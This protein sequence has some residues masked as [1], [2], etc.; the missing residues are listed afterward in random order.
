[1]TQETVLDRPA[2]GFAAMERDGALAPFDFMRR[3]LRPEDVAFDVLFCGICH[4]DLHMIGK[5]GQEYPLVPGHEMVGRVTEVGAAASGFAQGDLVAVSVIVDSCRECRP[6]Q[7]HDETYCEAGATS[8][9]D[10][11]DRIDG[12]RTRGGFA[13]TFVA[14]QRFVYHLPEGLDP[15]GAAPLLCAGLTSFAPMRHWKIGPGQTVGVVG[16]G[17]LGHLGVKFARAMGA[18]VVAFTSTP[19]KEPDALALGAHEVVVST[20]DNAMARQ[21]FRFDFILDTVSATHELDPFLTALHYNGVLCAVGIPDALQPSPMLLASGRRSLASSGAGGTREVAEML[22]FC[23]EHN[24]VADIEAVG[25]G[26]I[27]AALD[28]LRRNDVRF[29]FVIDIKR[30]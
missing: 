24:I 17:G 23:A 10:A 22:A 6:C 21:R 1:M 3:A 2:H 25:K 19:G 15:A 18:H 12:T 26:Q 20:D 13:D 29:R 11:V 14:D 5:W 16:I 30:E 28:R 7:A 27:N 8:T 4:T 9:Y